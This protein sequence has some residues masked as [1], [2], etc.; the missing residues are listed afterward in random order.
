[1]NALSAAATPTGTE[2]P[3]LNPE[4][5][6]AALSYPDS[7]SARQKPLTD[8]EREKHIKDC[9]WLMEDAMRRYYE[10]GCFSHR[11]EADRWRLLMEEAIR[12]RSAEQVA[13]LERERG[14]A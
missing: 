12:G 2:S 3:S 9:A 11:G 6:P 4:A 8:G 5:H 10:T 14:L 7:D 1:M 13:R